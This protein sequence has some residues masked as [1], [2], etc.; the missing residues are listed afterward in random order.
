[1]SKKWDEEKEEEYQ[2]WLDEIEENDSDLLRE[3]YDLDD[4]EKGKFLEE[5]PDF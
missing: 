5:H 1:M 3:W 4:S 2:N